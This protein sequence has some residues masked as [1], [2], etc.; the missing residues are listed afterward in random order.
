ME[1]TLQAQIEQDIERGEY[2]AKMLGLKK[3]RSNGRYD[4]MWGDKTALGLFH[5]LSRAVNDDMDILP[6]ISN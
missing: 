3:K 1:N 2:L 4:T 5:S 6:V